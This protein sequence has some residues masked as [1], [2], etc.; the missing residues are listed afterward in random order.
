[1]FFLDARA[2]SGSYFRYAR[3]TGVRSGA[4][5]QEWTKLSVSSA[6][7]LRF[8]H[9]SMGVSV[10]YSD[11]YASQS[12]ISEITA[13]KMGPAVKKRIR[14]TQYVLVMYVLAM[15]A[16]RRH[17]FLH[18]PLA[19]VPGLANL[20]AQGVISALELVEGERA[21]FCGVDFTLFV[22]HCFVG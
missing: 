8:Y 13:R 7:F 22:E 2:L 5:A 3:L 15:A 18:E 11:S 17:S 14:A 1:M 16:P 9:R 21:E 12:R 6:A 10:F 19:A 4:K 20:L